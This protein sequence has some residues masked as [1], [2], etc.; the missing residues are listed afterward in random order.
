MYVHVCTV[1]MYA[2][3]FFCLESNLNSCMYVCMYVHNIL[4]VAYENLHNICIR[5]IRSYVGIACATLLLYTL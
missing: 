1:Y 5:I 2:C 3:G 4:C